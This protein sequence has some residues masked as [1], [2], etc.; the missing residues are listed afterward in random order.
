M[1]RETPLS[2]RGIR[3]TSRRILTQFISSLSL[4]LVTL[5]LCLCSS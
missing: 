3:D 5:A 2:T 4:S 1:R